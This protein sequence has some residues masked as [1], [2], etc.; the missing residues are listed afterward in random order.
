MACHTG[1][2]RMNVFFCMRKVNG[3]GGGDK[4]KEKNEMKVL[5]NCNIHMDS[6]HYYRG[7]NRI[8][9]TPLCLSGWLLGKDWNVGG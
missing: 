4:N 1:V 7:R 6:S 2:S 9:S 3:L 5:P 8:K